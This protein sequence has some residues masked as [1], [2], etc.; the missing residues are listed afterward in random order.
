MK[1]GILS[2]SDFS[3]TGGAERMIVDLA[4]ALKADVVVP[5]FRDEIVSNFD[6]E[7]KI[8]FISLDHPLPA[9][10]FRQIEGMRLFRKTSLEYDFVICIDD[11][12]VRYLVHQVPHLY[13]MMTPRR[14]LYDMYYHFL[15][16]QNPIGK[17][18]FVPGLALARYMDRQFVRKHVR[19]LI[20]ISHTARNRIQKVYLRN[21]RVLYPPIHTERFSWE[22]S[23]GYW[24][25]LGRVDKWKRIDLQIEAFRHMPE[26]TLI[27]VGRIYPGFEHIVETA[28]KNVI[29]KNVQSEEEIHKLYSRCEG[30]IT[31]A[32]DEDFGITPLE[33]MASGKPVVA[34]REGG[35]QETVIDGVCGRLVAP[36]SQ[37]IVAAVKEVSEKSNEFRDVCQKRAELFDFTLF[38][39]RAQEIIK[40][41]CKI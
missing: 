13:Y 1:I 40:S 16:G 41:C 23:E 6:P 30:F 31:T 12:A 14:A 33:A 32:I 2:G 5:T 39:N 11:I 4:H 19:N 25:S 22:P 3:V 34:V 7:H 35:Y 38:A 26:K 37:E 18:V 24:L 9:E 10:P 28:P 8:Q 15:A 27:V 21:A 20:C 29:W 36:D 17:T